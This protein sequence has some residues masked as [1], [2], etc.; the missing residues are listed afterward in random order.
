MANPSGGKVVNVG[1]MR[2]GDPSSFLMIAG[3]CSLESYD[4]FLDVAT[5][6]KARGVGMLRGGMFKMRT[7]PQAFQGLGNDS[8]TLARQVKQHV[9]LPFVSEVTDPR[10]IG[11]MSDVV[12]MFQVGSRNM[13]NYTLLSE[14]GKTKVPVM[15]KRSFSA[16]VDEWLLAAEYIAREGNENIVLCE[17]GIRT[18]ETKT[19][20]TLDLNAVAYLKAHSPWP[21]IVD[22]SH[23]T[24]RPDLIPAMS[25]AAVALGADGLMVEVHPNPKE[26]KSDGFQAL[27]YEKLDEVMRAIRPLLAM[28]NRTLATP[29]SPDEV[30]MK[31]LSSERPLEFGT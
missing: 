8:F 1:Q 2:I 26:A 23:G 12:D 28:D 4:Q 24:G 3:P 17:R 6:V 29:W 21:V 25:R 20:N 5:A 18:F 27:T 13:F 14:I 19:R 16:L 9:G 15:L 10:Q 7:N 30:E 22:P 31:S 11:P